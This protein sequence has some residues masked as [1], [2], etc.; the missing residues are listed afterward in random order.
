[1]HMLIRG[2]TLLLL[3]WSSWLFASPI[4]IIDLKNRPAEEVL[5]IIKP[6]LDSDG[7]ISGSG[8]QLI[9]RTSSENLSQI[10]RLINQ[11]DSAP[12]QL[13]ISV[14]QGSQRELE[15]SS[16]EIHA[17]YQ[18]RNIHADVGQPGPSSGTRIETRSGGLTVGGSIKSTRTRTSDNPVQQLRILEGSAGYIETG[19][20]IPYFSGRV[21]R[22]HGRAIVET[23]TDYKDINTGFYVKPRING[24]RVVLE[25]NPYKES[26]NRS[27]TGLID[28]QSAST[29][30]TGL[31]GKW[32]EIGGIDN[33]S[34][35]SGGGI[36]RHYETRERQ[37]SR[38]WIKAELVN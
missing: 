3:L 32:I 7:A 31:V 8:F 13:L 35:S 4:E 20:S 37:S 11:I 15:A 29:T 10:K 33:Q 25:I 23:G 9:I 17:H 24:K 12:N 14:F 16:R 1:M 38:L 6:M 28:T 22:Q 5:P 26:L 2:F 19:Q 27:G 36:G 18:D 34:R 21:Y 30:V